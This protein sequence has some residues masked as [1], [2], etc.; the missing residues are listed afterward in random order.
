M[1]GDIPG[2]RR[3]RLD[4]ERYRQL[5]QKILERAGWKCQ[6]CSRRNQLQIHHMIRRSQSGA[7]REENLI[8]LRGNCHRSIHLKADQPPAR[9]S[10][11]T[12]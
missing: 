12:T 8:V 4:P 5:T 7:D 11:M 3:L 9:V 1:I 2:G 6:H 10:K